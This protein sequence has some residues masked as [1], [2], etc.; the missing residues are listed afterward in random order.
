MSFPLVGNPSEEIIATLNRRRKKDSGQAGMTI[1]RKNFIL[2]L[3]GKQ[4]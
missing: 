3:N 2:R 4:P 1:K